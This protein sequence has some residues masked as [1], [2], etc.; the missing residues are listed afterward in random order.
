VRLRAALAEAGKRLSSEGIESFSLDAEVLLLH[1]LKKD[2]IFIIT[3]PQYELSFSEEKKYFDMICERAS[4]KPVSYI[5]GEKEFM[6]LRFVVSEEVLIPR[7]DTETLV[8]EALRLIK[9]KNFGGSDGGRMQNS[10]KNLCCRNIKTEDSISEPKPEIISDTKKKLCTKE[11]E[12]G[13]NLSNRKSDNDNIK[14]LDM[15]TGSG[16]I[17]VSMAYYLPEVEVTAADIS[18]EALEIARLNACENGVADRVGFI[19]SDLFDEIPE[20]DKFD[21]I[22][23]NPPYIRREEI[24]KLMIDVKDFEPRIALDGGEDGLDFYRK[25]VSESGL[26]LKCGG[27]LMMEIGFDQG[28]EVSELLSENENYDGITVIKDLAGLDRVVKA[29]RK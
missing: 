11:K 7:P 2:R 18:P 8:E 10:A 14:I 5:T 27:I 13:V 16:A 19:E 25:I 23:S 21:M 24:E 29:V 4:G 15:C 17:A 12:S 9:E 3:A 22:L 20:Y 6:G 28:G 26:R 1:A